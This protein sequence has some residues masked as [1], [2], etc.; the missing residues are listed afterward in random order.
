MAHGQASGPGCGCLAV[1]V[2]VVIFVTLPYSL[3]AIPVGAAFIFGRW[4]YKNREELQLALRSSDVCMST[5]LLRKNLIQL[6]LVSM[7]LGTIGCVMASNSMHFIYVATFTLALVVSALHL[8]TLSKG[9]PPSLRAAETVLLQSVRAEVE[10]QEG[11]PFSFYLFKSAREFFL[12]I[13]SVVFAFSIATFWLAQVPSDDATLERLRLFEGWT[14]RAHVFLETLKF[15]PLEAL[16]LVVALWCLRCIELA[17]VGRTVIVDTAWK[18]LRVPLK[19]MEKAVLVTAIGCCL[20]FLGTGKGGVIEPFSAKIRALDAEYGGFQREVRSVTDD[21]VRTNLI[22]RAWRERPTG[23]KTNLRAAVGLIQREDEYNALAREASQ[24]YQLKE[25]PP[26]ELIGIT[27]PNVSD[28]LSS[29]EASS[30]AAPPNINARTMKRASDDLADFK[31]R[32]QTKRPNVGSDESLNEELVKK[33]FEEME[34]LEVLQ[35]SAVSFR[36]LNEHYPVFGELVSTIASAFND[37]AFDRIRSLAAERISTKKLQNPETRFAILVNSEVADAAA[38]AHFEWSFYSETWSSETSRM[39]VAELRTVTQSKE[40]LFKR[41]EQRQVESVGTRDESLRADI[42]K[43]RALGIALSDP[44]LGSAAERM[45][46]ARGELLRESEHWPPLGPVRRDLFSRLD[47]IL[48]P[49]KSNWAAQ[50]KAAT[51]P[52]LEPE[53]PNYAMS[54]DK[55]ALL[56]TGDCLLA[57]VREH[58]VLTVEESLAGKKSQAIVKGQLGSE[59]EYLRADYNHRVAQ[60]QQRQ[61]MIQWEREQKERQE[62]AREQFQRHQEEIRRE[63]HKREAEE[64]YEHPVP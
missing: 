55:N 21:A 46:V 29:E 40:R 32:M 34:P 50:K 1:I 24:K 58:L 28:K 8:L 42:A 49:V 4:A 31:K 54:R 43:L 17:L 59:F 11:H 47:Q 10:K 22:E 7:A 35:T 3:L 38:E 51:G 12:T 19:T 45:D 36:E 48:R 20:T 39:L 26:V 16:I 52:Y 23:L 13:F 57:Y 63:E 27:L 2:C 56:V 62:R 37:W 44:T 30:K 64:R 15:S 60:E 18:Q 25:T 9:E 41:S 33:T 14:E 53:F 5:S 61:Q 6:C